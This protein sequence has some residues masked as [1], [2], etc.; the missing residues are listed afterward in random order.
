[1]T[2][3]SW[4]EDA[5]AICAEIRARPAP[6]KIVLK[7]KNEPL[8]LR[9]MVEHHL[10]IVGNDG[11]IVFDNGS[12]DDTVLRYL[13]ELRAT[14][15]VCR[16]AAFHNSIHYTAYDFAPLYAALRDSCSYFTFLD[17]DERLYWFEPDGTY[18]ADRSVAE[19]IAN[20]GAPAI[21]GIWAKNFP[22]EERVVEFSM[23]QR[24]RLIRSIKNG[25]IIVSSAAEPPILVGHNWQAPPAIFEGC[26]VGNA[27]IVHLKHLSR[28][29][30][31]ASNLEKLSSYSR[32]HGLLENA[33]L[34]GEIT[35]E[36]VLSVDTG[37][38]IYTAR[39]YFEEIR[40]LLRPEQDSSKG[41]EASD[42]VSGVRL[43]EGELVFANRRQRRQMLNFLDDPAETIAEALMVPDPEPPQA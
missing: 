2:W 7:T 12:T 27:V 38:M 8:L 32:C 34:T 39:Q 11:L 18:R 33:G 42:G 29:Q 15:Q 28:E 20:S 5:A 26:A 17:T 36:D 30:R 40:T 4:E 24:W 41:G 43:E 14:V 25:K 35:L 23:R 21:P 19:R 10:R 31:I 16:F 13:D 37:P 1:M 9:G 3:K 22:G 6:L